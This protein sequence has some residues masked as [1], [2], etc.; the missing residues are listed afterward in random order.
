[1][2][3]P[4][5]EADEKKSSRKALAWHSNPRPFG[6]R[7]RPA[8][9]RHHPNPDEPGWGDGGQRGIRTLV[10]FNS[11]HAFQACAIDHSAI[12]PDPRWGRGVR[13]KFFAL[14]IFFGTFFLCSGTEHGV[15]TSIQSLES[16]ICQW[17]ILQSVPKGRFISA[18]GAT[19]GQTSAKD[20]SRPNG[21]LH[22]GMRFNP[23]DRFHQP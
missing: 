9:K 21:T 23:R 16:P 14:A 5:P 17:M 4:P 19:V 22:H 13:R 12:C 1:V 11:E 18:H 8:L 15:R 2:Q 6:Q 7:S 10:T 20:P 3:P